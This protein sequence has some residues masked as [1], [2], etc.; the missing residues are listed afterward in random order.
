MAELKRRLLT[1]RVAFVAQ[2]AH[3]PLEFRDTIIGGVVAPRR[4]RVAAMHPRI[5]KTIRSGQMK[6]PNA[7][8][9][10]RSASP[11]WPPTSTS[12]ALLST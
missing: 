6:T 3:L 1:V 12:I 9:A 2:L 10:L 8:A 11:S 7:S 5:M 4:F